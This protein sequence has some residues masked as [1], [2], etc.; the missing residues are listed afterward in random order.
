MIQIYLL[1]GLKLSL[2]VTLISYGTQSYNNN[3][4][5]A[6]WCRNVNKKNLNLLLQPRGVLFSTTGGATFIDSGKIFIARSVISVYM[7]TWIK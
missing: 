3:I 5:T 2:T 6:Q 4:N 1:N 7:D